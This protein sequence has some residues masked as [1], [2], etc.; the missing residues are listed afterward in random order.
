PL[1]MSSTTNAVAFLCL[2]FVKSEALQDLGIFASIAI[3]MSA[4]FSIIIIPHLFVPKDIENNSRNTL[5]DRLA[6]YAFEKNKVLI[7]G[8]LLLIGISLFTYHKVTF[9]NDL[10]KLNY[11]PDEIKQVEK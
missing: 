4:V 5:L 9:D 2:L 11:I 10:S 7:F 1:I 3:V 8:S 6:S